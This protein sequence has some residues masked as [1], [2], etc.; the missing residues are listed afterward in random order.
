M[1][2]A[3][4][5]CD[6]GWYDQLDAERVAQLEEEEELGFLE[7]PHHHLAA[8]GTVHQFLDLDRSPRFPA[9]ALGGIPAFG[10]LGEQELHRDALIQLGV[11]GRDHDPHP[12]FT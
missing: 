3:H 12:A 7:F 8:I 10:E 6:I 1:V 9:E 5:D 4:P 11:P 2:T